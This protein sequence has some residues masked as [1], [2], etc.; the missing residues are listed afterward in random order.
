MV[1]VLQM[2]KA[3]Q[4]E[5]L[6]RVAPSFAA[7]CP[8]HHDTFRRLSLHAS[9]TTL[10]ERRQ[11]RAAIG[12]ALRVTTLH[13]SVPVSAPWPGLASEPPSRRGRR[14]TC[15]SSERNSSARTFGMWCAPGNDGLGLLAGAF[16]LRR[17]LGPQFRPA[18][19]AITPASRRGTAA[20]RPTP[21]D[22]PRSLP[23]ICAARGHC[24][25][26]SDAAGNA[27]KGVMEVEFHC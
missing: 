17:K 25:A 16:Q 2:S 10:P 26:A 12:G 13:L 19:L 1:T 20:R 27:F 14:C 24:G 4:I 23:L 9:A 18:P 21:S 22:F 15:T 5:V 6:G 7:E 3:N 11:A 8:E